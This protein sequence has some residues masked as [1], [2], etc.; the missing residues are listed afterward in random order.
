MGA[1]FIYAIT[2]YVEPEIREQFSRR[3]DTLS[4]DRI[5]MIID[6]SFGEVEEGVDDK[7]ALKKY[8]DEAFK[9][10]DKEDPRDFAVVELEGIPYWL[11]GGMSW[12][13]TT[14]DACNYI[15]FLEALT[16]G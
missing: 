5:D 4:Q 14:S 12:G 1:D 15:C 8:L 6:S 9:Y 10:L 11:A 7:T 16:Y 13:D 2:K 3:V